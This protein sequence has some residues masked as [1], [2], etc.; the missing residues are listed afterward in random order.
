M[1][2][3]P[4]R[5]LVTEQDERLGDRDLPLLSVSALRG[6]VPRSEL[7]EAEPR[8]DDLSIYK[9]VDRGDIVLNR[10]SAYQGALGIAKQQGIAS[11]DY[12]VLRPTERADGRYLT[13]MMRSSWFVSEM[14]ARLRGVGG[15]GVAHVRTP[16]VS[17]ADLGTIP[18]DCPPLD[19]Q[20]R[21]ADFLDERVA[22]I[23][24]I[25]EARRAQGSR[26]EALAA[27]RLQADFESLATVHG[28]VPLRRALAS[29]EQGWS[30]QA[31]ASPAPLEH[32]GVMRAGAVNGGIFDAEDNKRLPEG[33]TPRPEYEIHA[34]DL[35]MSRASGSLDLIGSVAVVPNEVR[36]G[37]LLPDKIYR[38]RLREGWDTNFI[39]SVLRA[40]TNRERIRLGVSGAEGMANNLPSGV[41]RELEVPWAPLAVQRAAE[42]DWCRAR[43][44]QRQTRTAIAQTITLLT[45]YKQSLITAAV[46]GELDVTTASTQIPGE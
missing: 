45:E 26:S 38:L 29:I 30:P 12:A 8:A 27:A 22:R 5:Y 16:R 13:H 23:D 43:E 3:T 19:E 14:V 44:T 33:L 9:V 40:H 31:E 35:L 1:S 39:A 11:P 6:V 10:M 21:I 15:V 25:I 7:T 4:F 36:S 41:I 34:G 37:L 18:T 24:R 28:A 17:I 46:T 32:W 2:T 20:R 42:H